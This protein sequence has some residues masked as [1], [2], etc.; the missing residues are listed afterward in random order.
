MYRAW[1]QDRAIPA[2]Q[3]FARPL[4]ELARDRFI[5]G[6]PDDLVAEAERC[7]TE[8]GA[9]TMLLRIQWPGMDQ[10]RILDQIRLI[11]QR[12]IPAARAAPS[13]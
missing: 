7:R 6:T 13:L 4:E 5:I 3:T 9:T 8:L 1:G 10:A 2:D 11:G 12:V